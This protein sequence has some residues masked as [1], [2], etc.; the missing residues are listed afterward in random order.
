MFWILPLLLLCLMCMVPMALM[1]LRGG[2]GRW[3]PFWGC[4]PSSPESES[5]TPRQILD[6]RYATGEITDERYQAMRAELEA[7]QS[8]A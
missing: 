2:G 8:D 7:E 4:G 3:M 5:P 1:M 6:R